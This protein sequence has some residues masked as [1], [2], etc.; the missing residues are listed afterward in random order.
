[1]KKV[2]P[3]I[4]KM[5][6]LEWVYLK[7]LHFIHLNARSLIPKMFF[8]LFN[9]IKDIFEYIQRPREYLL[10]KS[11]TRCGIYSVFHLLLQLIQLVDFIKFF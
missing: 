7:G 10:K 6:K 4:L 1:M 5:K 3:I 9:I 8:H 11:T 2:I